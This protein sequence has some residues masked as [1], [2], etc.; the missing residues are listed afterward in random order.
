MEARAHASR[1]GGL[2]AR[3]LRQQVP[4]RPLPTH[5]TTR[6]WTAS[7][8]RSASSSSPRTREGR[9][10]H[11]LQGV[12]QV[13]FLTYATLERH[14][15]R[16]LTCPRAPCL[17]FHLPACPLAHPSMRAVRLVVRCTP[18]ATGNRD[19]TRRRGSRRRAKTPRR[20]SAAAR[21]ARRAR[22]AARHPHPPRCHS[23]RPS[24]PNFRRSKRRGGGRRGG[25]RGRRGGQ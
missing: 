1:P 22:H 8:T 6:T 14:P 11:P 24:C 5:L 3:L 19:W 12:L 18:P 21:S 15:R 20:A 9:P 23:C 10:L 4:R 17:P 16:M 13:R 7:C 2:L 25:R